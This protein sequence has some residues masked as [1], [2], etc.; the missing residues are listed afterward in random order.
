MANSS[1][2]PAQ[3]H[4]LPATAGVVAG[5]YFDQLH[6]ARAAAASE[7]VSATGYLADNWFHF[8]DQP[9]AVVRNPEATTGAVFAWCHG[10]VQSLLQLVSALST[11]SA[12][13]SITTGEL[14]ALFQ[15][16]LEPLERLLEVAVSELVAT[17]SAAKAVKS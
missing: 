7:A 13:A 5:G 2:A 12:K 16:R 14:S 8:N 15:H 4:T 1:R 9:A 10:E 17:E 6:T 11:F 3:P